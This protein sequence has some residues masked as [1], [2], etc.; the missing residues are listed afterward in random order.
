LNVLVQLSK[1]HAFVATPKFSHV[2][3]NR[4]S[5]VKH[6]QPVPEWRAVEYPGLDDVAVT[7]LDFAP[8]ANPFAIWTATMP[9]AFTQMVFARGD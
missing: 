9:R 8:L 4:N 1:V 6:A 7:S 2:N 3:S 5:P